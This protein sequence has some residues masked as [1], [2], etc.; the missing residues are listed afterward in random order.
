MKNRKKIVVFF[1]FD[2]FSNDEWLEK[3]LNTLKTLGEITDKYACYSQTNSKNFQAKCK[4]YNL[5]PVN[6]IKTNKKTAHNALDFK[7]YNWAG[8]YIHKSK[9]KNVVYICVASFDTDFEQLAR[10]VK[11]NNKTYIGTKLV[12]V[13]NEYTKLCNHIIEV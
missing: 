4:K 3:V 2:H 5:K 6:L 8:R 9:Y 7:I 12:G 13:D 1:D 10:E 11:E